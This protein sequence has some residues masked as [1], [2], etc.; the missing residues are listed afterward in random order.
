MAEL[1]TYQKESY[2]LYIANDVDEDTALKLAT[3]ELSAADYKEILESKQITSEDQTIENAGYSV[4]LSDKTKKKVAEK[5]S[6]FA[7]SAAM[8][9]YSGESY[10]FTEY[11]PKKSEVVE[12]YGINAEVK[13]E[14]PKEVRFALSLGINNE[15]LTLRD[16]KNL[17]IN[18][19]LL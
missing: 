17:Y 12:A 13:N 4:E 7:E 6:A 1:S 9:D 3:G 14:L 18:E 8:D 15:T 2:N 11:E 19:Y 16:A 5:Q 10:M